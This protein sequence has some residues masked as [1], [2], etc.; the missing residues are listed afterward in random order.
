[1]R[2]HKQMQSPILPTQT[3]LSQAITHIVEQLQAPLR[4]FIRGRI[5]SREDTEDLLQELWFQLSKKLDQEKLDDPKAWLYRVARNKIIDHYRRQPLDWLEEYYYAEDE[6]EG[7]ENDAIF[8]TDQTA[9]DIFM[10]TQF[11]EELYEALEELPEKQR[12]VFVLHE[13]E[14]ITLREIAERKGDK[15]KT[16]ISRKRYAVQQLREHLQFL[17]EDWIGEID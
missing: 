12:E 15:L 8:A 9:E 14:G 5:G 11:W 17:F 3:Q 4:S 16:I 7:Y 2:L 13:M 1:M 6:E 10:Q